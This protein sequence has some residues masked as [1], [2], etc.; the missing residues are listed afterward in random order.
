MEEYIKHLFAQGLTVGQVRQSL[1]ALGMNG[2]AYL[3]KYSEF[4]PPETAGAGPTPNRD[5]QG[6]FGYDPY[7]GTPDTPQPTMPLTPQDPRLLQED[8]FDKAA[9]A[10]YYS[11]VGEY[12]TE[13]SNDAIA[14]ASQIG[15]GVVP[16]YNAQT[17]HTQPRSN[18]QFRTAY[19]FIINMVDPTRGTGVRMPRGPV[20]IL[21]GSQAPT[22]ATQPTVNPGRPTPAHTPVMQGQQSTTPVNP[23]RPISAHAPVMQ[24]QQSTAPPLGST[25]RRKKGSSMAVPEGYFRPKGDPYAYKFIDPVTVHYRGLQGKYEGRE[26]TFKITDKNIDGGRWL[27]QDVVIQHR[28]MAAARGRTYKDMAGVPVVQPAQ[29]RHG[30]DV[31][32]EALPMKGKN[33][34]DLGEG[35]R[36]IETVGSGE[37][38]YNYDTQRKRLGKAAEALN[39]F[40]INR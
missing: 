10:E 21:G 38:F 19:D 2:D 27:K 33:I 8:L 11:R 34:R 31:L 4:G 32:T 37:G 9:A 29:M 5:S 13:L 16:T 30:G 24:E 35:L 23:G 7:F 39:R 40:F 1:Q 14:L 26:G 15:V 36:G 22:P 20:E 25:A 28:R 6:Y 3:R 17:L 12:S 18:E